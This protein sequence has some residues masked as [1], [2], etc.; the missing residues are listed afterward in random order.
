LLLL[1]L[2]FAGVFVQQSRADITL[3]TDARS[4]TASA[5]GYVIVPTYESRTDGP[6][7]KTPSV[8]FDN[9]N[10]TV[11][12]SV[13]GTI[14]TAAQGSSISVQ[15]PTTYFLASGSVVGGPWG[16][17]E[18]LVSSVS[19]VSTYRIRFL[20]NAD[21]DYS[22]QFKLENQRGGQEGCGITTG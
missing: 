2:C 12:A 4:I 3:V 16:Y 1:A 15:S 13:Y 17:P 10:Q 14:A 19:A 6:Y 20:L 5:Q 21:Y 11:S 8:P 7:T 22:A 18:T 9:F